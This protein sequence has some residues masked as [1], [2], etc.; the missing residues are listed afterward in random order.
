MS[1]RSDRLQQLLST[2]QD[3]VTKEQTRIS[4]EVSV[5]QSILNG[6]TGGQGIQAISTQQVTAVAQADLAA[7]LGE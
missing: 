3:Y 6:R 2:V 5:L 1:T 7:F 4:N